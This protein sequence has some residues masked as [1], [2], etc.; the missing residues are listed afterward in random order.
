VR[1]ADEFG[2][3]NFGNTL[4]SVKEGVPHNGLLL[5]SWVP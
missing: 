4:K 2:A 5:D 3:N 1:A